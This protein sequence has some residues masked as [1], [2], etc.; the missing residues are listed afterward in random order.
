MCTE[1]RRSIVAGLGAALLVLAP[2]LPG[3]AQERELPPPIEDVDL[4]PEAIE[5]PDRVP[6]E[7]DPDQPPP[8]RDPEIGREDDEV[9]EDAAPGLGSYFLSTFAVAGASDRLSGFELVEV[10]GTAPPGR[11]NAPPRPSTFERIP[12]DTHE[13]GYLLRP[14]FL[15]VHR[16]SARG[17]VALAY[18]PELEQLDRGSGSDRVSHAAGV[19]VSHRATRRTDFSAGASYLDSRDPSRHLGADGFALIRGRL[20]EQRIYGGFSQLWMRATRLHLYGEYSAANTDHETAEGIPLDASDLSGTLALEQGIGR[21]SDITLS[22]SVTDADVKRR[23]ALDLELP[24][25]PEL[26]SSDFLSGPVQ[27]VRLGFGHRPNARISFHIAGGAMREEEADGSSDTSWVG[28]GE[29]ARTGESF[30]LRVRYDRSLFAFGGGGIAVSEEL[31]SPILPGTVLRDTIADTLSFHVE[32][33]PRG[34]LRWEQSIWLSRRSVVDGDDLDSVVT[35]S[36]LEVLLTRGNAARVG[37]FARFD[38]FDRTDSELFG[39]SLSRERLSLGLRVG[40]SG[41]QTKAAHRITDDELRRVL[42]SGGR[43]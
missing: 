7:T 37:L 18:E 33:E 30:E 17:G 28:S 13:S 34:R 31:E 15:F 35:A 22:Y 38:Y 36:L 26:S 6:E 19:T 21:K 10:P 39:H 9:R 40:L 12:V 1:R 42:P 5:D 16:P 23:D 8:P 29:V 2:A 32:F 20:E 11:P 27:S 25:D 14:S 43:L 41:P 3:A 24:R 4:V